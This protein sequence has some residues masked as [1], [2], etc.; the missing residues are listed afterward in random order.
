MC[1]CILVCWCPRDWICKSKMTLG[2]IMYNT[3]PSKQL[4]FVTHSTETRSP[5]HELKFNKEK[6]VGLWES[7]RWPWNG[8]SGCLQTQ[9]HF[10]IIGVAVQCSFTWMLQPRYQEDKLQLQVTHQFGGTDRLLKRLGCWYSGCKIK[11]DVPPAVIT[12]G[13]VYGPER[14]WWWLW[15]KGWRQSPVGQSNG[16]V[17]K[18]QVPLPLLSPVAGRCTVVICSL[19]V[20]YW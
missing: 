8:G 11:R 19:R 2:L 9:H 6:D 17:W 3:Q 5:F 16:P 10:P 1:T 7:Q 4:K 14:P 12:P 18:S 20:Q 15:V 13:Q